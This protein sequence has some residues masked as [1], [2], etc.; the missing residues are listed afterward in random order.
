[1]P[2]T[3]HQAR[4]GSDEVRLSSHAGAGRPLVAAS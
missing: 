2:K 3:R 1:M 4:Q